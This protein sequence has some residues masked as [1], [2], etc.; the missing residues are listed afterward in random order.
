MDLVKQ[1]Q[2]EQDQQKKSAEDIEDLKSQNDE[3]EAQIKHLNTKLI[4]EKESVSD[5]EQRLKQ[6]KS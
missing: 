1:V 6:Q 5:L 4:L 3:L 2:I